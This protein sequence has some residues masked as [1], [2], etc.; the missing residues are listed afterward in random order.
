MMRIF[1]LVVAAACASA[2]A[3][4]APARAIDTA[5][6]RSDVVMAAKKKGVNPALFATGIDAKK[7]PAR[8]TGRKAFKADASFRV[9]D[10]SWKG[11]KPWEAGRKAEANKVSKYQALA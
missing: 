10:G 7:G 5:A 1:L 4:V 3:P 2:F 8:G 6:S 11:L 9:Q